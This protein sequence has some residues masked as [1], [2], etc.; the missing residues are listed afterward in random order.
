MAQAAATNRTLAAAARRLARARGGDHPTQERCRECLA[1]AVAGQASEILAASAALRLSLLARAKS[2]SGTCLIAA[3]MHDIA[4]W[5]KR[6]GA[7]L[8]RSREKNGARLFERV[9]T[10]QCVNRGRR[11]TLAMEPGGCRA[12]CPGPF[13][14]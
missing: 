1:A 9:M 6:P 3:G 13:A 10:A 5:D 4:R 8:V 14:A 2:L 12:A 7:W 11:I